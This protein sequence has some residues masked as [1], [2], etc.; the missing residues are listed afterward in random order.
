[1]PVTTTTTTQATGGQTCVTGDQASLPTGGAYRDPTDINASN[2]FNTYVEN[3][4]WGD[5]DIHNN[6]KLCASSPSNW[7]IT[8]NAADGPDGGAVQAYPNVQQLYDNWGPSSAAT[9]IAGGPTV[10]STFSTVNPS[11]SIGQWESGYDLWFDGYASDIMVWENT[12]TTRLADNGAT[13]D[14]PNVVIGGVSYT[15]MHYGSGAQPERM[16]VRHTNVNSG[17]ENIQA[18]MEYLQS[19]GDLPSTAGLTQ[20]DFGWELC[21]TDSQT[22][23][24]AVNGY[25]LTRT[26]VQP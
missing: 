2:G 4:V 25:T 19:I 7:N 5:V 11:D 24:Y 6:I 17:T 21:D 16:L 15:L 12:S 22:L 9:P 26:P 18:D 3:N 23:T 1:M 13:I 8:V 14:D 20:V 10:T